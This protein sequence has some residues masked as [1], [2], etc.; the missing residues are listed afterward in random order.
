MTKIFRVLVHKSDKS[1]VIEGLRFYLVY[2][3]VLDGGLMFSSLE[4]MSLTV[5][6]VD[7]CDVVKCNIK[8]Y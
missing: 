1:T 6:A 5:S 8:T 7:H 3:M 4:W 2:D